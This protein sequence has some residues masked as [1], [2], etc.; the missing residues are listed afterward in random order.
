[1]PA[2]PEAVARGTKP[3]PT[4]YIAHCRAAAGTR[5][6]LHSAGGVLS[7]APSRTAQLVMSV[8]GAEGRHETTQAECQRRGPVT[9]PARVRVCRPSAVGTAPPRRC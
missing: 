3:D 8:H 6:P 7:A 9:P 4:L 1:M 2:E 5:T